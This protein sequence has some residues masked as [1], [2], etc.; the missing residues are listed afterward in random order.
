M[1]DDITIKA[2]TST[3]KLAPKPGALPHTENVGVRVY[4]ESPDRAALQIRTY[5]PLQPGGVKQVMYSHASLNIQEIEELIL[6]LEA[7]R[8][9]LVSYQQPNTVRAVVRGKGSY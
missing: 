4:G 6:L 9:R 2:R 3:R 1:S 7:Q 8:T 5:G